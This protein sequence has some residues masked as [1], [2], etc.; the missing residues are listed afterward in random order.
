[1]RR[2]LSSATWCDARVSIAPARRITDSLCFWSVA[3]RAWNV[4]GHRQQ[5]ECLTIWTFSTT[6]TTWTTR[7]KVQQCNRNHVLFNKVENHS[8]PFRNN[9]LHLVE[10]R[11]ITLGV[12][13]DLD[14]PPSS[15]PSSVQILW[16]V[17]GPE[18]W[19][20]FAA[21]KSKLGTLTKEW[22]WC[23]FLCLFVWRN[24]QTW[25]W[26]E[27]KRP[28]LFWILEMPRSYIPNNSYVVFHGCTEMFIRSFWNEAWRDC[29]RQK[30]FC[31]KS[32]LTVMWPSAFWVW[33]SYEE[34]LETFKETMMKI[35]CQYVQMEHCHLHH[36]HPKTQ[37][38]QSEDVSNHAVI[39][40]LKSSTI[41]NRST[42]QQKTFQSM[43]SIS[44]SKLQP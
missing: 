25:I 2:L 29:D 28:L 21:D 16:M 42:I 19:W 38:A 4:V 17:W 20:R 26:K 35:F 31:V 12:Q 41:S 27:L 6:A 15:S 39:C 33:W 9:H 23:L 14:L 30:L 44:G 34:R 7:S 40:P 5:I 8:S 10:A 43:G 18:S 11:R 1:M 37:I 32:F 36:S 3:E 13:T 24:Q 22:W